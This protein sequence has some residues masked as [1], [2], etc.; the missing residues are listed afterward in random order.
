MKISEQNHP[1]YRPLWRRIVIVLIVA[2][3][4]ASEIWRGSDGLWVA[5][6]GAM[7]AYAVW[8]FLIGFPKDDDGP[9]A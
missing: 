5:L 7:L 4:F 9:P 1:F 8:T 6:S 2:A 3:W